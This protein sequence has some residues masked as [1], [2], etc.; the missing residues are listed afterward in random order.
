MTNEWRSRSALSS[1]FNFTPRVAR[2]TFSEDEDDRRGTTR[3]KKA[4]VSEQ[5]KRRELFARR[6]SFLRK[7]NNDH[8][9]WVRSQKN[10]NLTPKEPSPPQKDRKKWKLKISLRVLLTC[11]NI[12]FI[13]ICII[14]LMTFSIKSSDELALKAL[15]EMGNNFFQIVNSNFQLLFRVIQQTNQ[16]ALLP[17][18]TGALQ[19][20]ISNPPAH[21]FSDVLIKYSTY[22]NSNYAADQNG[23]FI[24]AFQTQNG[25][26]IS[27]ILTAN[28]TRYTY[29]IN[30]DCAILDLNCQIIDYNT[31]YHLTEPYQPLERVWYQQAIQ[32]PLEGQWISPYL[33]YFNNRLGVTYSISLPQNAVGNIDTVIAADIDLFQFSEILY[34]FGGLDDLISTSYLGFIVDS[35]GAMIASSTKNLYEIQTQTDCTQSCQDCC[36]VYASNNV[37]SRIKAISNFLV[38]EDKIAPTWDEL[39]NTN[40]MPTI[41]GQEYLIFTQKFNGLNSTGIDWTIVC[42]FD[43]EKYLLSQKNNYLILTPIVSIILL[44]FAFILSTLMTTT[45]TSTLRRLSSELLGIATLDLNS[46]PEVFI[47]F[48]NFFF[49]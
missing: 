3:S 36:R 2:R 35:K 21:F 4:R 10:L 15:Q 13:I 47:Y 44:A 18:F 16:E 49:F 45:L 20:S 32:N 46:E 9:F 30:K 48:F 14:A 27:E 7:V 25:I 11:L 24:G 5:T 38:G 43:Y 12:L 37:N 39:Q 31:T 42:V 22:F 40:I 29:N 8:Q 1:E 17:F 26:N 33:F 34:L 23:H 28:D 41:N 19:L 6:E